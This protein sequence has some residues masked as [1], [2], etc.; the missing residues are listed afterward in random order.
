MYSR[1]R[2]ITCLAGTSTDTLLQSRACTTLTLHQRRDDN[3]L[4]HALRSIHE[5]DIRLHLDVLANKHFFLERCASPPAPSRP[6]TTKRGEQ[7][8][9]VEVRAESTLRPSETSKALTEWT[10]AGTWS[11]SACSAEATALVERRSTILI[12]LL[13]LLRIGQDLVR[14]LGIVKLLLRLW[15]PR[16]IRMVFFAKL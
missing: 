14:A 15:I 8:F 10:R 5:R 9:K 2:P 6:A 12:P 4:L 13:L 3:I 7:V 1:A 11:P 16:D